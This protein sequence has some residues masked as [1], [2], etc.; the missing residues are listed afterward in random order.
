MA[1]LIQKIKQKSP[2]MRPRGIAF[3]VESMANLDFEDKEVWERLERVIMAKMDDFN[4]HYLVKMMFA[5]KKMGAGSNDFY[6]Q[7]TYRI[8]AQ[9]LM[10]QDSIRFME[11]YPEIGYIFE[12]TMTGEDYKAFVEVVKQ[13]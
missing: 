6:D 7:I 4:G 1:C 5:F 13:V 12:N 3:A 2:S 8:K 9:T 11:I 10:Y